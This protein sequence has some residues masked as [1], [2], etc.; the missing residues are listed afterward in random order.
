MA[1]DRPPPRLSSPRGLPLF[2]PVP[3]GP[4]RGCVRA[5]TEF[6]K[7]AS[8]GVPTGFSTVPFASTAPH[9]TMSGGSRRRE[10]LC[11]APWVR[12]GLVVCKHVPCAS[13]WVSGWVLSLCGFVFYT[14]SKRR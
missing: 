12:S 3:L 5:E 6:N 8:P 1:S 9:L 7:D 11:A 4:P 2:V 10:A 14:L 13:L